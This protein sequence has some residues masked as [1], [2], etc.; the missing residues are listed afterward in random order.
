MFPSNCSVLSYSQWA[1]EPDNVGGTENCA[2]IRYNGKFSDKNC[3]SQQ[4]YVCK[5][6]QDYSELLFRFVVYVVL[7]SRNNAFI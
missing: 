6:T 3:N 2:V 4:Y 5:K 7:Q 1:N